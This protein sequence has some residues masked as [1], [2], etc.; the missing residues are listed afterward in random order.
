MQMK[1][2]HNN[3]KI[4]TEKC[5]KVFQA[6]VFL[7]SDTKTILW[8]IF[9]LKVN[10]KVWWKAEKLEMWKMKCFCWKNVRFP[11]LTVER[12]TTLFQL[13]VTQQQNESNYVSEYQMTFHVGLKYNK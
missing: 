3:K 12:K 6:E 11:I 7:L 10:E 2:F 5:Q 1:I 13:A 4:V 8:R 9:K